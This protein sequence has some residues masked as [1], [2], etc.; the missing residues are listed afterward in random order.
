MENISSCA[1]SLML[2][3]Y[4]YIYRERE[5]ERES[6]N[7]FQQSQHQIFCSFPVISKT[8]YQKQFVINA[9]KLWNNLPPELKLEQSTTTFKRKL[10]ILLNNTLEMSYICICLF[11]YFYLYSF[12]LICSTTAN[13]TLS[14][15]RSG[16][17][18]TRCT[19]I[20]YRNGLRG[21]ASC[22]AG[23]AVVVL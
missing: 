7:L 22:L 6:D 8:I 13:C 21:D 16:C 20:L 11:I 18:T 23:R 2:Y 14:G 3:I 9:I 5:R 1:V 4:I 10:K 17:H 15:S 12:Y 19:F